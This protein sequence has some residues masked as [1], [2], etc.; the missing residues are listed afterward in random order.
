MK[1]YPAW[2]IAALLLFASPALSAQSAK[3]APA[4]KA[5]VMWGD[6][7]VL[8]NAKDERCVVVLFEDKVAQGY[9]IENGENC[10]KAFPVM[11]KIKAWRVYTDGKIG[12]VDDQGN[13]LV[14]FQGKG[15]KRSA[16]KKVDGIWQIW[17]A[18]E[19]AE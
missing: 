10:S 2:P 18:Q 5:Q 17:S 1:N 4:E 13:D 16:I 19:V 9:R 11:A 8:A 6:V 15:Y 7:S 14:M 12:F 3:L